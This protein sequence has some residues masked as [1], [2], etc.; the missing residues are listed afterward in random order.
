MTAGKTFTLG[1]AAQI[2]GT[3]LIPG[4]CG[5]GYVP[6]C[7]RTDNRQ[8]SRGEGF[9]AI[10]G[11]RDDGHNYI[12]QAVGAGASCVLLEREYFES[13]REELIALG[14]ALLPVE[15]TTTGA[16]RLAGAWL[17][18]VSPK[19]IGI[20]GSVGKT[21][22]REFIF[23]A[24][25]DSFKT[26]SAIKSYNT[27]IGTSLTI[28]SM[29][30]DADILILEL[31]TNHPGEI[32]EMVKNFPVTHGIITEVSDAHLE[33]LGSIEGVLSAKMEITESDSLAYLSYN[34]DN[35]LLAG[36]V[37][38]MPGGEKLK[39]DGIRQIGV[40]YSNSGVRISDVR[41]VV[42]GAFDPHLFVTLSRGEKKLPC[43]APLFGKQHAKNIGFAYAAC[44]QMGLDDEVFASAASS[45][46]V[47]QGRGVIKH[48]KNECA[49]I[50]ETY[51]ANPT[52]ISFAIKNL[53]EMEIPEGFRR[54]AILGGMRELGVESERLHEVVL[55]RAALLDEVYLIGSEWSELR[56][57]TDAVRGAWNSAEEFASEFGAG[58]FNRSVILLKG[59][60]FYGLE[61][62]LKYLEA[63]EN[64]D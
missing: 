6:A 55:S 40:G 45:F 15:G 32:R 41:Q 4:D 1:R 51:N 49:L 30:P 12:A 27:L 50:D 13:R 11:S 8:I 47:P 29:P 35:E 38:G 9:I 60:L 58:K 62:L 18:E 22:T 2:L 16:A 14:T 24:L 44:I 17:N 3:E 43:S 19:V 52:S 34:S 63:G 53:L 26:H 33:G 23:R 54:I 7:F 57:K 37:A 10:R 39:K 59:S 20:T 56:R 42:N 28:L 36:A 21:T 48:G 25:K 46:M 5:N 61:H 31:G 64:A